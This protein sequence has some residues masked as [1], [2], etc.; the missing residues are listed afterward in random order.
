MG[1]LNN[2]NSDIMPFYADSYLH[3]GASLS[4]VC[5]SENVLEVDVTW[6]DDPSVTEQDRSVVAAYAG[7]AVDHS[8]DIVTYTTTPRTLDALYDWLKYENTLADSEIHPTRATMVANADG[9]VLDLGSYS[10]VVGAGGVLTVGDKFRSIRTTGTITTT[11]GGQIGVGFQDSTGKTILINLGAQNTALVYSTTNPTTN[12]TYVAPAA[13]KTTHSIK[14]GAASMVHI[15]AKRLGHDYRKYSVN[16]AHVGDISVDL[17][18]NLN[19][20]TDDITHRPNLSLIH[21]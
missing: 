14:V 4:V 8:T 16:A 5:K 15:T 10:L 18:Q 21:I 1:G 12:P 11:G 3:I 20:D 7:L 17:P 19:V 6:V 2:D 9:T 13:G